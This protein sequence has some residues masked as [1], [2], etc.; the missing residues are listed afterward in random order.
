MSELVKVKML[1]FILNSNLR[2]IIARKKNIIV[3]CGSSVATS[4]IVK[5]PLEKAL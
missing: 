5:E 3:A 4:I 1:G 2:S